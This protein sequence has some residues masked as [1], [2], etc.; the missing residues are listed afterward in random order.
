MPRLPA[1]LLQSAWCL[2]ERTSARA[3]RGRLPNAA[4]LPIDAAAAAVRGA[5][6]R[7]AI[8]LCGLAATEAAFGLA[9]AETVTVVGRALGSARALR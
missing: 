8:T 3:S 2:P 7:D 6:V 5:A 1:R 9:A 4:G